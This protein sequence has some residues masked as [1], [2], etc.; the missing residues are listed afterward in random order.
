M[1]E[2]AVDEDAAVSELDKVGECGV[3]EDGA[4]GEVTAR[5]EATTLFNLSVFAYIPLSELVEHLIFGL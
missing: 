3:L 4:V 1:F 5:A 2:V